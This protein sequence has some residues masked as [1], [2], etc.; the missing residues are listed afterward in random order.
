MGNIWIVIVV[1]ATLVLPE[2]PPQVTI[3]TKVALL[4]VLGHMHRAMETLIVVAVLP[5]AIAV[6]AQALVPAT[7]DTQRLAAEAL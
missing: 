6:A 3:S 5:T 4:V 1:I 2:Q 7:V